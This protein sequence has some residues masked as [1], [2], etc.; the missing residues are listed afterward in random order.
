MKHFTVALLAGA[1][2]LG[3]IMFTAQPAGATPAPRRQGAK[4]A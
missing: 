2:A 3:M 1:L 4:T